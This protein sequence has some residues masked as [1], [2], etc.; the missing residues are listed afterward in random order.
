MIAA[1]RANIESRP[2]TPDAAITAPGESSL[3]NPFQIKKTEVPSITA[4]K[5]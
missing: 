1:T 4:M 3:L 2:T 5:A